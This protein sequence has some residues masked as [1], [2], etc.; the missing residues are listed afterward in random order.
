MYAK[1]GI[2]ESLLASGMDPTAAGVLAG[3]G[4][5]VAQVSVMGAVHVSRDGAVS[6]PG[7]SVFSA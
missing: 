3:A 7:T 6:D 5:G 4:G 1:E 2:N